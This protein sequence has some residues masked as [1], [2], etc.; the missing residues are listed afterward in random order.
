M[1]ITGTASYIKFDM[2]DGHILKADGEMLVNRT[3]VVY[4]DTMTGWE[5]PFD[6]EPFGNEDREKIIHGVE[7]QMNANTVKI[8]FE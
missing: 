4:K 7:S 3:F 5:P 2:E 6:Q 8:V 1:K